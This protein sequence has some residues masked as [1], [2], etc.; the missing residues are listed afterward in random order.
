M[1]YT[2]DQQAQDERE[3]LQR[4]NLRQQRRNRYVNITRADVLREVRRMQAQRK[5]TK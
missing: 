5:V 2:H 1:S 4:I 3:A